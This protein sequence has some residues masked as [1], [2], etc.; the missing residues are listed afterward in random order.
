MTERPSCVLCGEP[1]LIGVDA[2]RT[3]ADDDWYDPD[4]DVW[5]CAD[6]TEA[7]RLHYQLPEVDWPDSPPTPRR[8]RWRRLL[9]R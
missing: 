8:S 4:N 9:G 6:H 2:R 5:Y 3:G 7:W 1:A